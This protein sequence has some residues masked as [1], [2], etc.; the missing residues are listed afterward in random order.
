MIYICVPVSVVSWSSVYVYMFVSRFVFLW[1]RLR[2]YITLSCFLFFLI[3]NLCSIYQIS[4]A[5]CLAA[6]LLFYSHFR[7]MSVGLLYGCVLASI[8]KKKK[9]QIFCHTSRF[10]FTQKNK[11]FCVKIIVLFVFMIFYVSIITVS[12]FVS[13]SP[14]LSADRLVYILKKKRSLLPF[15]SSPFLLYH[16]TFLYLLSSGVTSP[17]S[18]I[19]QRNNISRIC[20]F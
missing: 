6:I 7:C 1:H 4:T 17:S 14:D 18:K 10:F 15:C 20:D 5:S 13:F 19:Q 11:F 8:D 12:S 16:H 3:F 9:K 2:V